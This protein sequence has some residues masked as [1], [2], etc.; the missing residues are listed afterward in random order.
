M[1]YDNDDQG[2]TDPP[3]YDML[4]IQF[5]GDEFTVFLPYCEVANGNIISAKDDTV[6]ISV[7]TDAGKTDTV[8][9]TYKD[10]VEVMEKTFDIKEITSLSV[11]LAGS[12]DTITIL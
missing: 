10:F 5:R 2:L 1:F 3:N 12:Y 11:Q 7:N 9:M 6:E 4:G 8:K